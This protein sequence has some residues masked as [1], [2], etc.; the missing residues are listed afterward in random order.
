MSET[1]A[2]TAAL[3]SPVF[4]GAASRSALHTS[5]RHVDRWAPEGAGVTRG[6]AMRS[7]AFADRVASPWMSASHS[8]ASRMFGAYA[9]GRTNERA[10]PEVSWLFP[11][12]WFQDELDWMAAARQG[13]EATPR[14]AALTTRGTF[15]PTARDGATSAGRE[16]SWAQMAMP[17]LAPS[18]MSAVAPSMR[19]SA[20]ADHSPMAA[21]RVWSPSVSFAAVTAAEVME[22]HRVTSVLVVDDEGRLVGA[23]NSNDLMR[24]KVI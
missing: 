2:L 10:T 1:R 16:S 12:P 3:A 23:L 13:L 22:R 9:G 17:V 18:V 8:A 11:R 19:P 4:H 15:M 6:G 20:L 24:A 14:S 5:E 21:G 7:L